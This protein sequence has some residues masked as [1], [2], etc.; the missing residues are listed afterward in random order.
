MIAASGPSS[1][2]QSGTRGRKCSPGS[3]GEEVR[4]GVKDPKRGEVH[5]GPHGVLRMGGQRQDVGVE[6]EQ[7]R[8][9]DN[10]KKI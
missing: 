4:D 7:D 9:D 10:R 2:P 1:G 8:V 3:F 5:L 6:A